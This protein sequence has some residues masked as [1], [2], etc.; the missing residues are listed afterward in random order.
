MP[1]LKQRAILWSSG[2][3]LVPV[4]QPRGTVLRTYKQAHALLAAM[5]DILEG[6]KRHS[7]ATANGDIGQTEDPSRDQSQ[8]RRH[9]NATMLMHIAPS[10]VVRYTEVPV[11][12]P[13]ATGH[14]PARVLPSGAVVGLAPR[15]H[16][17]VELLLA[18]TQAR[19]ARCVC[20]PSSRHSPPSPQSIVVVDLPCPDAHPVVSFSIALSNFNSS[21]CLFFSQS[22]RLLFPLVLLLLLLLSALAPY[23]W[24]SVLRRG[25]SPVSA[26]S[27][28]SQER[29]PASIESSPET[30]CVPLLCPIIPLP[31]LRYSVFPLCL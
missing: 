21:F 16:F 8:L 5:V 17:L 14:A 10:I 19:L 29:T 1:I 24:R 9:A 23:L 31:Q 18:G 2:D 12:L 26:S 13:Y 22:C 25:P 6:E 27:G 20:W 7:A 3:R 11:K 15:H 30:R 4:R 28:H